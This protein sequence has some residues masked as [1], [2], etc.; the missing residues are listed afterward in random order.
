MSNGLTVTQNQIETK[1][2]KTYQN[3][4]LLWTCECCGEQRAQDHDHTISRARCKS[5]GKTELIWDENNVSQS[6]RECHR[7]WE[8][9]RNGRFEDH[10][11]VKKRMLYVKRH[12]LEN[13][14]K[15]M[16]H[17]NNYKLITYLR[18]ND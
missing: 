5:I 17:L 16:Q 8:S 7:D 2:K 10:Q 12:D 13:F 15:R 4:P 18:E 9:Y 3:M 11:N 6:C 14:E 1:L